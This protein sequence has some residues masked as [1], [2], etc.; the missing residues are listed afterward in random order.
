VAAALG[1][2]LQ[3]TVIVFGIAWLQHGSDPAVEE[4]R[5][6][7]A[8]REPLPTEA[9]PHPDPET[10]RPHSAETST[11]A[12]WDSLFAQTE[13]DEGKAWW[14][15][16]NALA[17]IPIDERSEE[18]WQA[19][20]VMLEEREEWR[21]AVAETPARAAYRRTSP[22]FNSDDVVANAEQMMLLLR[23]IGLGQEEM[24]LRVHHGDPNAALNLLL[25]M[26]DR[27]QS[28]PHGATHNVFL[29]STVAQI[30][31]LGLGP[32]VIA[33]EQVRRLVDALGEVDF[34]QSLA[35]DLAHDAH[36]DLESFREGRE[37]A[38]GE[39]GLLNRISN[40]I[41]VT[42]VL[43]PDE[44]AYSK[45]M[46][47]LIRGAEMPYYAALDEIEAA[48]QILERHSSLRVVNITSIRIAIT[49][50]LGAAMDQAEVDLARLGLL[51]ELHHA[52]HGVYP[53][54]LSALAPELGGTVPVDPFTGQPYRYR[55]E[56]GGFTLYSLGP[57][58]EDNG[59]HYDRRYGDIVW[60]APH[61][62]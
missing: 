48:E 59:G 41:H 45:I 9:P 3:L 55:P 1:G 25:E 33:P 24:A 8:A 28:V 19:L 18:D 47:H 2:V 50:V 51:I 15:A 53:E 44:A 31:R 13:T 42:F 20:A 22:P 27:W 14:E 61:Q 37:R 5:D 7:I 43:R 60:R 29:L 57:N 11:Q 6:T 54:H 10:A 40:A 4:L 17:R 52:E 58:I 46:T 39:P 12:N 32:G 49:Q 21:A 62:G 56:E 38:W 26:W 36:M 35:N 30:T 23:W 16:W 34:Q